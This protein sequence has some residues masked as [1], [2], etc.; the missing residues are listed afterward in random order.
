MSSIETGIKK[1][2]QVLY[3]RTGHVRALCI[4]WSGHAAWGWQTDRQA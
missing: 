3:K 4:F 2:A 1:I